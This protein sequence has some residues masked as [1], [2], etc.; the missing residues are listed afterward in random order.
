MEL[1]HRRREP[2]HDQVD[3]Q[4]PQGPGEK[5]EGKLQ[6]PVGEAGQQVDRY[7]YR[8]PDTQEDGR[9]LSSLSTREEMN[10]A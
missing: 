5:L 1:Q 9:G 8:Y 6:L 3:A 10:S 7:G 2:D 4:E